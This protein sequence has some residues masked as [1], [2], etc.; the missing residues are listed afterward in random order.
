[1]SNTDLYIADVKISELTESVTVTTGTTS[2]DAD[3]GQIL[4]SWSNYKTF[5]ARVKYN[6]VTETEQQSAVITT[7]TITVTTY[8]DS[9]VTVKDRL[10]YG[11]DIYDIISVMPVGRGRFINMICKLRVDSYS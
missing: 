4:L 6:S 9:A 5:R 3:T 7:N 2:E 8:Y 1:M 10:N 11:S